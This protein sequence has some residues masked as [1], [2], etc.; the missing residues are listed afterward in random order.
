[1]TYAARFDETRYVK[2]LMR[3]SEVMNLARA[4]TPGLWVLDVPTLED[5]RHDCDPQCTVFLP[6]AVTGETK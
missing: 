6:V 3:W 2:R 4:N 5:F 1:M